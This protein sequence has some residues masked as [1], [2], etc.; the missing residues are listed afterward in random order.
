[1][2]NKVN[3]NKFKPVLSIYNIENIKTTF[4]V[5]FN[6]IQSTQWSTIR[7]IFHKPGLS[8]KAMCVLR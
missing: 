2:N 5:P 1:M 6:T 7:L 8:F 4:N 3:I